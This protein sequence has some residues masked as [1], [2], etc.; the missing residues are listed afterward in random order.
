LFG[1]DF[2]RPREPTA[3]RSVKQGITHEEHKNDREKRQA[4]GA[5]NHFCLEARAELL[6][7]PLGPEADQRTQEDKAKNE[8]RGDDETRDR[9]KVY[10]FPP[11][12]RFERHVEGPKRKDGGEKKRKEN[13]T[14]R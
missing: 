2:K 7:T 5:D 14:D 13:A 3:E 4:H 11:I 10:D 9:V 6:L 1:S 12:S 8:K